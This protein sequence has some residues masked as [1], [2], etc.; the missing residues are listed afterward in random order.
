VFQRIHELEVPTIAAVDGTCLGGGTELILACDV[1]IASDR[2]ETKIGLPEI[3]LGILPGFGGTTRL[4][5]LIGLMAASD[6]ILAGKA[7]DARKAQKI[8][9]IHERMHAGVLE[10]RAGRSRREMAERRRTAVG[11]RP[12]R[13]QRLARPRRD[14]GGRSS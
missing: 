14:R 1:R 4:P 13:V 8:G 6:I 9:L 10:E 7:V 11:N 3:K 12:G 5:R 2:P